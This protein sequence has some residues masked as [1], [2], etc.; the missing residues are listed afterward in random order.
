VW[1]SVDLLWD[2]VKMGASTPRVRGI[3][4]ATDLCIVDVEESHGL[5]GAL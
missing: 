4:A 2:V 5:D 3:V 1:K